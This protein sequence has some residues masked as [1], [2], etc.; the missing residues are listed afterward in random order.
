MHFTGRPEI[1]YENY[2]NCVPTRALVVGV[3]AQEEEE[4]RGKF[5][6]FYYRFINPNTGRTELE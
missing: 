2:D 3:H 1:V 5:Y 6:M 4:A